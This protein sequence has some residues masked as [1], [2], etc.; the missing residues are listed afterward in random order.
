VVAAAILP[1][2]GVSL[3][4]FAGL[5]VGYAVLGVWFTVVSG[6]IGSERF[7]RGTEATRVQ[8]GPVET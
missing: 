5:A 3:P 1:T 4:V 2:D 8:L 6:R 7:D